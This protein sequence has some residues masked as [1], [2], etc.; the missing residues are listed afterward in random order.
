MLPLKAKEK[1]GQ[2]QLSDTTLVAEE[3]HMVVEVIVVQAPLALCIH[4][5]YLKVRKWL[6]KWALKT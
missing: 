6:A 3:K 1:A 4:K 2:V 5:K